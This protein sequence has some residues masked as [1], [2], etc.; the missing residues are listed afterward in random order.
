[1]DDANVSASAGHVGE[2]HTDQP[3]AYPYPWVRLRSVMFHPFIFRRMIDQV[4]PEATAGDIVA[5]YD[6]TGRLF[7]HGFYHNRSQI[8]LRMLS[9][10]STAVDDALFRTRIDEAVSWREQLFA[11]QSDTNAWRL[12]HAEGDRISGLIAERYAD[13]IAIEVFS[14]GIFRRLDLFKRLLTERTGIRQ[15]VV[16]ADDRIQK[17]EGFRI[18]PELSDSGSRTVKITE[19]GV[20]FKVNVQSGH[21]TGFFCDQRENRRRLAG[22]CGGREVLDICCYTGGFGIYAAKL[23]NATTVTG[24]DLDENAIELARQNAHLNELRIQH[25]HADAFAYLRQMQTN[26]RSFDVVV[27]DPPKFVAS[28]DELEEGGF[29]YADL[30]ALAM[31]VVKPGGMLLTCSCSGLVSAA[32]FQQ[33]VIGAARRT[34]RSLQIVDTTGAGPDHPVMANCPESGYLKAVWARVW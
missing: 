31:T 18:T 29:K 34:R 32:D 4:A 12:V 11:S 8:A 17:I 19:H 13:W 26:R 21:K 5:V 33:I 7:G 6:R 3:Q 24:V 14:M 30:N 22:L 28:K 2:Q 27:V 25:I 1:M 10:E 15:F 16:R 23:G 9:Y 20:R